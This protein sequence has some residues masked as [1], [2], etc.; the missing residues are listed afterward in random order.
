MHSATLVARTG[1]VEVTTALGG[2]VQVATFGKGVAGLADVS[3]VDRQLLNPFYCDN[4]HVAEA[5]CFDDDDH[6]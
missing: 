5:G 4:Y 3:G 6:F 2:S 1:V